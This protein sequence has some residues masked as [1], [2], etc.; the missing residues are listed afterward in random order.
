MAASGAAPLV[1]DILRKTGYLTYVSGLPMGAVRRQHILEIYEAARASDERPGA[2]LYAFLSYMSGLSEEEREI[3]SKET[4]PAPEDAVTISTIHKAKGLEYPVVFLADADKKF[5]TIRSHDFLC[6][7]DMG[8][9]LPY[10]DEKAMPMGQPLLPR[11]EKKT[12]HGAAFRRSQ[13]P[14][15]SPL[16]GKG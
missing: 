10:F 5:H 12:G 15:C 4:L 8:L 11:H 1:K 13:G 16:P 9:S 3:L 6:H 14:L 2:G 7:K